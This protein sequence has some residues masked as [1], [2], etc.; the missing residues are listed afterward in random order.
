VIASKM[1]E[2]FSFMSSSR[3]YVLLYIT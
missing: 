2:Y 3:I 1:F